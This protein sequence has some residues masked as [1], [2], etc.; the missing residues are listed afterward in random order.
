MIP[1]FDFIATYHAVADLRRLARKHPGVLDTQTIGALE[2]LLHSNA[3]Q[4]VRQAYF[5]YREAASVLTDMAIV[6]GGNGLGSTALAS[7]RHMLLKASGS[8][9]R[10]VAEA[11][12]SLP[13]RISGPRL[14]IVGRPSP[15]TAS[16]TDLL[17]FSGLTAAGQPRYIGRSLVVET[18]AK[19]HLLVVK[20]AKRGDTAAGL[21]REI[22]WMETIAK[23]AYAVDCRF[24]VPAPVRVKNRRVFR[25]KHLPLP[26]LERSR[27][28]RMDWPS[29][30][31][32]TVTTSSTPTKT[33]SPGKRHGKLLAATPSCW[34]V[35]PPKESSTRHP[36]H[37]F[38]TAPSDCAVRIRGATSGSVQGDW[39]SG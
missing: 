8:A 37:C 28:I 31:W 33:G 3:F 2:R 30:L 5:L 12:G 20:L 16:W 6:P 34:A 19:R 24:H 15:P 7:L 36:F 18:S 14:N 27:D 22:Q 10:G 39:T 17:S 38:T 23:P 25:I 1:T 35:W 32:P 9:H 13:V 29:P 11:L 21:E 4:K 26:P